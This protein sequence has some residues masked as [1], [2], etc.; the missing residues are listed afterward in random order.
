MA[1]F[2]YR[3]AYRSLFMTSPLLSQ[4]QQAIRIAAH[5]TR[6][7]WLL[8]FS[9][10]TRLEA[11]QARQL[12]H[13]FHHVLPLAPRY[14][15]AG[16]VSGL[17]ALPIMDKTHLMGE[18]DANNTRSI[19]LEDALNIAQ[20][21]ELSRNFSPMLG[22]I[23]VGMSSGTSG[24]R[25]LF[26][27]S[28]AERCH[29]AGSILARAL[30]GVLLKQLLQ[31]WKPKL[32]IAFFLRANSNLYTTLNSSRIDFI[33]YDLLEDFANT[34]ARLNTQQP[35]ILIAP[36][37]I[38]N[39][40]AEAQRAGKLTIHPRHLLSVAEV[41]EPADAQ[42]IH[43]IFGI[44]PH[45]IYQATEGFLGYTCEMGHFHLNESHLHIEQD[46]IDAE[47][48]RF[49][50]II[51]DFS[52]HTQLIVRYRL[53]DILRAAT[54]PC[55]CGRAEQTID[56]IEGRADEILWLPALSDGRQTALYPDILRRTMMLIQPALQE[57]SIT[58]HGIRWNITLLPTDDFSL[59]TRHISQALAHLCKQ[60]QIMMPD[61]HFSPW[62][63]PP[64]DRK[65]RRLCCL[66]APG[67]GDLS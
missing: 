11:W 39:A 16:P 63:P 19:R 8:N 51:T 45:Q 7:R 64:P 33:F 25:G 54:A 6:A 38:L 15:T 9:N 30:P 23:T 35:D 59:T 61:C 42:N 12:D 13:F 65:R 18:F 3:E 40:L 55:P 27:V 58:Q 67:S 22:D 31:P 56:S 24:T 28:Q 14:R 43:Q 4:R 36:A 48:T 2:L 47:K 41:L 1:A 50:P 60:H 49:H 32:R 21:A 17:A 37:T 44:S 62:Q 5:F 52:R 46:W 53:N 29:W 34:Q 26:L 57:Y 10:R 66:S 20:Q